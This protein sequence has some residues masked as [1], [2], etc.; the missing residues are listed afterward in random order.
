MKEAVVT[1]YYPPLR[2]MNTSFTAPNLLNMMYKLFGSINSGMLSTKKVN[3]PSFC[4]PILLP[5][6]L[7]RTGFQPPLTLPSRNLF[8]SPYDTIAE[9]ALYIPLFLTSPNHKP[10]TRPTPILTQTSPNPIV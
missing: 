1:C 8:S 4:T 6:F 10:R 2:W 3:N 5:S 9:V 7:L